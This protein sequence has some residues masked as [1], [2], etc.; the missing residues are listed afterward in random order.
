MANF[1]TKT[2]KE[3]FDS[4]MAKYNVLRNKYGDNSPLLEKSFIKSIGY[5]ISGV[6][7]TLWQ[8]SV[9]LYK[10]CFPQSCDLETLLNCGNLLNVSYVK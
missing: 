4:F 6:A 5:A 8:M 9:H 7:G 3:I 2:I 1:T 10:Q